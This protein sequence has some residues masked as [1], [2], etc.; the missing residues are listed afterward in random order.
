VEAKELA[1]LIGKLE[2]EP[3]P[4]WLGAG[5]PP[6]LLETRAGHIVA[7]AVI[8]AK[9][10][11]AAGCDPG[12]AA[13]LAVG[14]ELG[15]EVAELG[16]LAEEYRAAASREAVLARLAHELAVALQ[17]KKYARMGFDVEGVLKE[18]VAKALDEAAKVEP[19]AAL[20]LVHELLSA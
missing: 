13:A 17:A 16:A 2:A 10:A 18:H 15:G 7:E 19:A 5:I 3:A 20:Q 6:S 8:A 11:A 4:F 12:K 9:L 1:K 14:G